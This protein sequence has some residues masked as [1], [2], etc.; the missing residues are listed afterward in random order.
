HTTVRALPTRRSSDLA[1]DTG[2]LADPS[3]AAR[4][5][6]LEN[7]ALALELTVLR[8]ATNSSEGKPD[9]AS[10]VLKLQGTILQQAVTELFV[11]LAR[12]EE[13]TSELQSR[14]NL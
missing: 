5:A 11:D 9:P 1:V 12:S 3:F 13:H 7:E 2:L 8:V 6:D 10:S 14:E 4:I